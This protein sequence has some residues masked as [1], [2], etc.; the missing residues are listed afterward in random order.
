[1]CTGPAQQTHHRVELS[2][3]W[4]L[5]TQVDEPLYFV[6]FLREPVVDEETGETLEA[7]PSNYE[8]VSGGLAEIRTRV[9]ALQRKF[10]EESKV[11]PAAD[12]AA[13]TW[14]ISQCTSVC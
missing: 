13:S 14:G 2:C 7:H 9:E 4:C 5:P 8:A 11:W 12:Q 10:N 6:D 1:M 3:L